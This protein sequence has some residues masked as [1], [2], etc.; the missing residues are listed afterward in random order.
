MIEQR[1]LCSPRA[2][3]LGVRMNNNH[4]FVF[5]LAGPETLTALVG[6]SQACLLYPVG[7]WTHVMYL[8]AM[9]VAL[10]PVDEDEDASTKRDENTDDAGCCHRDCTRHASFVRCKK[11][12]SI[13]K[14]S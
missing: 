14:A 6:L 5:L 8:Q 11:A 12:F 10:P 13:F 9:Q 4:N 1:A 2:R 3:H 7:C